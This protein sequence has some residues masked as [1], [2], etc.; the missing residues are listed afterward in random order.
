MPQ[1]QEEEPVHLSSSA[2][3]TF[4]VC[5]LKT[6]Y[7]ATVDS[8]IDPVLENT[9]INDEKKSVAIMCPSRTFK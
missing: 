5:T 6:S 9:L 8:A 4:K 3:L 7:Y 1:N 2:P